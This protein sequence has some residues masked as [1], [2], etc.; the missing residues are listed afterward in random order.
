MGRL[1]VGM[2]EKGLIRSRMSKA[3]AFKVLA[4]RFK[5]LWNAME[6]I[7]RS[8]ECQ[9]EHLKEL[10][11]AMEII[12]CKNPLSGVFMMWSPEDR[13][14]RILCRG[15]VHDVGHLKIGV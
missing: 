11:N 13:S 5:E 10:W 4:G 1:T 6:I 2:F 12:P 3:D 8:M 9:S 7:S 14:V 15:A